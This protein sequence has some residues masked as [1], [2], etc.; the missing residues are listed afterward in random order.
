VYICSDCEYLA[1]LLDLKLIMLLI[2][3]IVLTLP[4]SLIFA[5][6]LSCCLTYT[7][8][9]RLYCMIGKLIDKLIHVVFSVSNAHQIQM[10]VISLSEWHSLNELIYNNNTYTT[11]SFCLSGSGLLF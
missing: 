1:V 9:F 3:F 5:V 10:H 4:R 11:C 2:E 6:G 7:L 8:L